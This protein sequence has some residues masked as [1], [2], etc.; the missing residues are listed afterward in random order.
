MSRA[1]ARGGCDS[2]YVVIGAER[3]EVRTCMDGEPVDVVDAPDWSDGMSASLLRGLAAADDSDPEAVLIH[4]VDLPDV[5]ASVV[6]RVREHGATSALVRATYRGQPGHPVLVRRDHWLG[7]RESVAG[8][9][10]AQTYLVQ[11]RVVR[12]SVGILLAKRMSTSADSRAD[13]PSVRFSGGWRRSVPESTACPAP[14]C[15]R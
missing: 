12:G 13:K 11:N 2:V 14:S 5:G 15:Q 1:L 10:G 4:L 8:D 9:A 7:L 3:D 6:E